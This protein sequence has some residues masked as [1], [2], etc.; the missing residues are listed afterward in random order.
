MNYSLVEKGGPGPGKQVVFV[1]PV[2]LP[3]ISYARVL[4]Q[5]IYY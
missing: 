1:L 3:V 5:G 2:A 4:H